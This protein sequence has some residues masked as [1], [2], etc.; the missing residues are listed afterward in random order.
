MA[1]QR[2]TTRKNE[3]SHSVKLVILVDLMIKTDT[4]LLNGHNEHLLRKQPKT[5]KHPWEGT[6]SAFTTRKAC[7][8]LA[9][10]GLVIYKLF[11]YFP[12]IPRG[13]IAPVNP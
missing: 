8:S 12:N 5:Q 4:I 9:S 13:F 1:V 6:V 2:T 7:K 10:L 3:E 11:S